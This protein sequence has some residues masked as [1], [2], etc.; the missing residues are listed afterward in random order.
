MICW[1][2]QFN[3]YTIR[4]VHYYQIKSFHID[5]NLFERRKSVLPNFTG[6]A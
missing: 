6:E 1:I 2:L 4:K 5:G 3:F